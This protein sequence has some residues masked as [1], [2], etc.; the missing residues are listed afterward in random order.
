MDAAMIAAVADAVGKCARESD[1][2]VVAAT[3]E[4]THMH[5]LMTY[6]P[7]DIENTAKWIGQ[8]TTKAVHRKTPFTGPVW[9]EGKWLGFVFDVGHWDATRRYIERHNERRGLA[10]RPWDW[11]DPT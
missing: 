8:Q 5:L 9:C 2:R 7:R 6:T 1:W 11:I 3:I 10:I 4:A